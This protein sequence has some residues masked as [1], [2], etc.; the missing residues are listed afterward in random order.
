MILRDL[1]GEGRLS[2]RRV[3]GGAGHCRQLGISAFG[4]R[5]ILSP[6]GALSHLYAADIGRGPDGRWWANDRTQ[7]P[8]G[9]GYA[10]E[11]RL[12]PSRALTNLYTSM[13]VERVAPFFEAF[14]DSLRA[15]AD[16]D[17]PRI[18]LLTPGSSSENLFRA[19]DVGAVSRFP[20]LVEG[21]DLAVSE[22][23]L[24]VRT[25]GLKRLDVLLRR[26]DLNFLDPLELDARSM[27]GVPG[28]IDVLRKGGVAVANMPGSGVM[29]A[30]TLLGFLPSLSQ[31]FFGEG[32]KMPHIATWWCG[33]K[34]AREEVLSRLDEMAIE[35]AYGQSVPGFRGAGQLSVGRYP[36]E[37]RAQLV[38]AIGKRGIDYVGQEMVRLSTTP[39][40]DNGHISPRPFVLRGIRR[41]HA[42][43][44]DHSSGRFLPH[45]RSAGCAR[46]LDG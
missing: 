23:R 1:Y 42:E 14:R 29:E 34:S 21:D 27:L 2:R 6:G 30:R 31:R 35:G 15:I 40:W 12:V 11:N 7:A 8:S 18:G 36:G 22:D 38:D 4:L 10:L 43:R 3:A 5:H 9:A 20:F 16:R 17:E 32:L 39:V 13:N 28:L 26:V 44:M 25:A 19:R 33:Q 24:H 41:R 45:R 46:G 37:E